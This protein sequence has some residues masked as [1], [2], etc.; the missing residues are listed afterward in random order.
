MSKFDIENLKWPGNTH[1]TDMFG[2]Q[3]A[4]HV[5]RRY[6]ISHATVVPAQAYAELLAVATELRDQLAVREFNGEA[7]HKDRMALWRFNGGI[8]GFPLDDFHAMLESG[9]RVIDG[10][11]SSDE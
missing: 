3:T 7:T 11:R 9:Q 6:R 5:D 10:R 4:E 2:P 1:A 8:P